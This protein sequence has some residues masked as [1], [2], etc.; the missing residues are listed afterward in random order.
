MSL[1][2]RFKIE[3]KENTNIAPLK[4]YELWMDHTYRTYEPNPKDGYKSYMFDG[5]PVKEKTLLRYIPVNTKM[6]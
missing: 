1:F 5:V 3:S 2:N 6:Q 4:V